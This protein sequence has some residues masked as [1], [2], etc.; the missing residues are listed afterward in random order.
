[1]APPSSRKRPAISPCTELPA[2]APF[3]RTAKTLT[4]AAIAAAAKAKRRE[5]SQQVAIPFDAVEKFKVGLKLLLNDSIYD[6]EDDVRMFY[7]SI[8]VFFN[9]FQLFL[10][11]LCHHVVFTDT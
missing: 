9:R 1:M 6:F 10:T 7:V 3:K 4:P 11:S 2:K 5:E 8:H